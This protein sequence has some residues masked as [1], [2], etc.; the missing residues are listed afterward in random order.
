MRYIQIPACA[1]GLA[2]L[3]AC[4]APQT[5]AEADPYAGL[6]E[7]IRVWRT[8][9][10]NSPACPA[11]APEAGVEGPGAREGCRSF[12][13]ACKVEAEPEAAEAEAGVE[14][15]A[16]AGMHWEAWD[17]TSEE[18]RRASSAAYFTRAGET[19]SRAEAPAVNLSTCQPF[20]S[21]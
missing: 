18:F 20:T 9:L 7:A 12:T 8:E 1:L 4:S 3:A 21:S 15:K 6:S 14:A 17:P 19:W 5:T 13:V 11:P 2:A 10:V 16:L